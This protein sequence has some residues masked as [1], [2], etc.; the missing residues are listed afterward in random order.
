VFIVAV[1]DGQGNPVVTNVDGNIVTEC[2]QF[3]NQF[4]ASDV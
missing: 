2:V 1:G 3:T 4:A